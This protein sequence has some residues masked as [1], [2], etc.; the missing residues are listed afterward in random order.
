MTFVEFPALVTFEGIGERKVRT[1]CHGNSIGLH[2]RGGSTVELV[3]KAVIENRRAYVLV[4]NRAEANA[5]LTV[6]ALV[7]AIAASDCTRPTRAF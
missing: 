7:D 3:Q 6:E 2:S 4:N 5:P 1:E